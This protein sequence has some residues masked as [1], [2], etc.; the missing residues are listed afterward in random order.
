MP[1]LNTNTFET[2]DDLLMGVYQ[3]LIERPS[4]IKTTRSTSGGDTCEII[5]V[6]LTL[7]NPRARLSRSEVK[8]K[9]FSPVG[10]LLWYLAGNNKVE[11]IQPYIPHYKNETDDGQTIYGAY[12]PRLFNMRNEYDQ[13]ANIVALLR[14]KPTSRRAVIQLF[15]AADL[16]GTHKEIPCT[17]TLQFL[18]RDNKLNLYVS[19]RSNDAY[20]GL[21]H[22]IFAFTMLQEIMAV[23]LGVEMGSYNHSAGSLHLYDNDRQQ[24][25]QYLYEGYQSTKYYMPTMPKVD[26][27]LAIK[28]II[29][30]EECIRKNQPFTFDNLDTYWIDLIKMVYIHFLGKAKNFDGI[31]DVM[32]GMNDIYKMYI[33]KRIA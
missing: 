31:K 6:S 27:W 1:K 7:T 26:P 18:L 10:E 33:D 22:D 19:M 4:S 16:F 21:P 32:A 13:V 23:T 2:L 8:G 20:M 28:Q 24:V 30:I 25:E 14:Q 5:G 11:F 12:G 3:D 29:E 9:A 17:C 15:D